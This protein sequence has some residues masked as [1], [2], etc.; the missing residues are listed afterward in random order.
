MRSLLLLGIMLIL[1]PM[2][3]FAPFTGILS[4]IWMAYT[5]PQ[6]WAFT[7][8][9]QY[10]LAIAV[11]TIIGYILFESPQKPP[12][13]KEHLLILCLMLQYTV[14]GYVLAYNPDFAQP[15]FTEFIK[16]FVITILISSMTDTENRVR[17]VLL[18]SLGT[19]GSLSFRSFAGILITGGSRVYGP[20]GLYEDNNDYA[21]LL[22]LALPM[23]FYF[24][25]KEERK[26]IRYIFLFFSFTSF[27]TILFTYS[28]GGF[29]GLCIAL[30]FMA[31]K[32]RHKIIGMVAVAILGAAFFSFAPK[33]VLNR[34][35]T[36]QNADTQDNSAQQR[37]RA[38]AV[39]LKIAADKPFTGVGVR[40]IL[41]VYGRYGD[42]LDTRVAHN[43]YLQIV[44]DCGIPGLIFFLLLLFVTYRRLGNARRILSKHSPDSKLISYAHGMQ[45]G[46]MGYM[47]SA[48]FASKEDVELIYTV[49]ALGV[50]CI[51]IARE[52]QKQA[53][54]NEVVSIKSFSLTRPDLVPAN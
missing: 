35:N 54:I 9:A 25:I 27:T 20:G 46:M 26:W 15:K 34:V 3:F 11:A 16:I 19:I 24:G 32:S 1:V 43:S 14:A 22:N 39:C 48:F 6:E 38:W 49:F 8:S 21:I 50:S 36:I 51:V 52:V 28:R 17:W 40:N 47:S 29:I 13:I 33:E 5:R 45:V 44:A 7:G 30:I 2:A 41:L 37:L 31:M 42:P 4:F 53:K 18:V 10:S 23:L 12:R